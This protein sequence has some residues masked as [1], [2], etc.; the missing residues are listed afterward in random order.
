MTANNKKPL[1]GRNTL[2]IS[3]LCEKELAEEA[4]AKADGNDLTF[5]QYLRRLINA[6]LEHGVLGPLR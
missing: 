3:F 4:W 1:K 6:D 5:S 2:K